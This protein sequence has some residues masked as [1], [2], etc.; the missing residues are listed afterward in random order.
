MLFKIKSFYFVAFETEGKMNFND[1]S[2]Y[3]PQNSIIN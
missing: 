3:T 1:V 2:A